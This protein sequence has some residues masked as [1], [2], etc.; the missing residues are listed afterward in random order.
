[1]VLSS[2]KPLARGRHAHP[3]RLATFGLTL[4][5]NLTAAIIAGYLLAAVFAIFDRAS[6]KEDD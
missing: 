2:E 1:M 4:V 6:P 5:V 3:L